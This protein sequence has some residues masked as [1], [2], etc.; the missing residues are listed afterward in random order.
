MMKKL[1]SLLLGVAIAASSLTAC[2][3]NDTKSK[4][5]STSITSE[6]TTSKVDTENA[7][8]TKEISVDYSKNFKIEILENGIKKV[9]DGEDRE[10]I[11]VPKSLGEIPAEYKDSI[12]I[13]TPVENAVFLSATQLSMLRVADNDDIWDAVGAVNVDRASLQGLDKITSRMDS[14]KIISVGG[15]MGQ[16]DYE[17]IQA[18]NPDV[19][20]L[21]TGEYG[22]QDAIAKLD[23]LG[24]NYAVDN[25]YLEKN[26]LARMEWMKFVLSFY[27]AEDDAM[28]YMLNTKKTVDDIKG[29]L[30][31][32]EGKK[33]AIFSMFDGLGYATNDNSWVGSI[34]KE[35][36]GINVFS[37][38]N[39]DTITAEGL[40]SRV[41]DADVIIY[42]ATPEYCDGLTAI[43]EAFPQIKECEAYKNGGVYQF[44]DLYWLGIDRTDIIASD[45]ASIINPDIFK[46]KELTYYIKL[47]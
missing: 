29:K 26:Y 23:E 30:E 19:V 15:E 18:L 22:Q 9:T 11:L 35:M 17:Q 47:K 24:I 8:E 28:N 32:V 7:S 46:D 31:G 10:L 45:L 34:I 25:D 44:S 4:E 41:Q 39:E 1:L 38:I 16:P 14:G 13:T 33:V 20:F 43:E 3:N 27:N 37:D 2:S 21:Y 36:G 6:S 42:S 12:V 40:F 5:E